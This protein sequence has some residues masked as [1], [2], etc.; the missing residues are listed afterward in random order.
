MIYKVTDS[1]G[2]VLRYGVCQPDDLAAQAREGET[3]T[4]SSDA[5]IALIKAAESEPT[6][7]SVQPLS[8]GRVLVENVPPVE[9]FAVLL[10]A[11][12]KAG[13]VLD[14]AAARAELETETTQQRDLVVAA[15]TAE[16]LASAQPERL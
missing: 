2:K 13:V 12:S 8:G 1:N 3:A 5:E 4:E 15:A 14:L 10:R 11:L 7:T 16:Q 9:L 6:S